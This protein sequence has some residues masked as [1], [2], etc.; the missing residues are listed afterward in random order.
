MV[1]KYL[2]RAAIIGSLILGATTVALAPA[3]ADARVRVGIGIGIPLFAPGFAAPVYA[4]PVYYPPAYYPAPYGYAP[5]YVAPPASYYPP[6]Q[7][8]AAAPGVASGQCREYQTTSV[9]GG[10]PQPTVG[11]A[12][13]Q[14][15]G[16]WR[17]VN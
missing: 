1:R 4:A 7:P 10:T 16:T 8:T 15:D 5:T 6:A 12:C 11:T 13:L 9:I 3:P 2:A 14:P 17:I